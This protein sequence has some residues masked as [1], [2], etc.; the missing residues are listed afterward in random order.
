MKLNLLYI[1]GSPKR[2]PDKVSRE[3]PSVAAQRL[4][5]DAVQLRGA[6]IRQ[7]WQ[8]IQTVAASRQEDA[9]IYIIAD[10]AWVLPT[11]TELSLPIHFDENN[12]Q[13]KL[14]SIV[15]L[16]HQCKH[17]QRI[18]AWTY[19]KCPARDMKSPAFVHPRTHAPHMLLWIMY[20]HLYQ[21]E[22]APL[23]GIAR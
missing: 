14:G 17:H 20:C 1:Y 19:S 21:L 12:F 8:A 18:P 2:P 16:Y 4:K 3:V 9:V 23:L 10:N 6:D 22:L 13:A 5:C 11:A 15:R 7:T